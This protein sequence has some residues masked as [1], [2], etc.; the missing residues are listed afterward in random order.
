MLSP[1]EI[2]A[3]RERLYLTTDS[4]PD[5]TDVRLREYKITGDAQDWGNWSETGR[6]WSTQE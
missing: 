1:E 6:I 3:N 2:P 5:L 4:E